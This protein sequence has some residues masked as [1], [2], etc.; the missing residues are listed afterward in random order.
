MMISKNKKNAKKMMNIAIKIRNIDTIIQ[1]KIQKW[2]DYTRV[3]ILGRTGVSKSAIA[4]AIIGQN[5]QVNINENNRINLVS[6]NSQFHMGHNWKSETLIPNIYGYDKHKLLICDSPGFEDNR[7]DK[8]EIINSF[9]IDQ[10]FG[11]SCK[12]KIIFVISAASIEGIRGINVL[13]DLERI[14][15]IIPDEN[16]LKSCICMIISNGD[17]INPKIYLEELTDGNPNQN[18][19]NWCNFFIENSND[20]LF[21]FPRA[22]EE[23]VGCFYQFS[24]RSKLLDFLKS[25]PVRNPCHKIVLN[26]ESILLV[27]KISNHFGTI[28]SMIIDL[29]KKCRKVYQLQTIKVLEKWKLSFIR[30]IQNLQYVYSPE[31][32]VNVLNTNIKHSYK[33]DKKIEKIKY[34]NSLVKLINQIDHF[35]KIEGEYIRSTTNHLF[36]Q[37]ITFI[38]NIIQFKR[39]SARIYEN[40]K[41]IRE[42]SYQIH[43]LIEDIQEVNSQ[44]SWSQFEL[45]IAQDR[46]DYQKTKRTSLVNKINSIQI[47]YEE[48]SNE[49]TEKQNEISRL[50]QEIEDQTERHQQIVER[51]QSEHNHQVELREDFLERIRENIHVRK[52]SNMAGIFA[53]VYHLGRFIAKK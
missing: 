17:D 48:I 33:V 47:R 53:P 34:Y 3:I 21:S 29:I 52:C 45:D 8:Q 20:R 51:I 2:S 30:I 11:G 18:L 22:T 32:L 7:G 41:K 9:A 25:K 39:N 6:T 37:E 43:P 14:L 36:N 1:N 24:D 13:N 23:Q 15:Q 19:V 28:E 46:Y 5:L 50:N 12:I 42:M 31:D 16:L 27:N 38:K 26:D 4:N 10:L 44:I 35:K 40:D 49:V